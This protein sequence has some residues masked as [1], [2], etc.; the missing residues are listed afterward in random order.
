MKLISPI[1]SPHPVALLAGLLLIPA[2]S[3]AAQMAYEG[4]D[5]A[6]GTGNLTTQNGGSGWNGAWQTVNGTSADVAAGSLAAGAGSPSGYD[7]RSLGNSCNLLNGKRTGRFLNTSTN[8]PFGS[9]GYRDGNGNIG[10]DGT[11]LYLSFTQQPNDTGK[12]YE[13]EFHR[14]DLGDPGRIAGIG[15]DTD[16]GN[17]NLRAPNGT[18]TAIGTGSTAVN[19]YVVRIDFKAGNDD[20]YIY[21]NPTSATNPGSGAATL[22]RLA[23]ADMSFNGISFGAFVGTPARTVAHDEIRLGQTWDDV[24]TPSTSAPVFVTQPQAATTVL[25]GGSVGL[26]AVANGFPE[27]TCQWYKGVNPIDGQTSATLTLTDVQPGDAGAYHLVA[28]NSQNVATSADATVIV[29]PAPAGL[30]AYEGFDYDAGTSNTNGKTGGLGWGGA[31]TA[32]DGGGGNVQSGSLA[33]GTN[34]PNGYDARSSANSSLVPNAKR[35]GRLLDT[36]PGGRF[37][38]AGY[39]DSNGNVGMDGKTLYLSFLQQPDGTSLFYEFEFHRGNLGDPGRIAGIGNDT[40]NA[41]VN[42]RAPNN[43]QSLIGPGSTGVNLYVVRIDFKAGNDDVRI[44]QNPVSATEPGVPT[45]TKLDVADMSFNGLSLAAFVN[46]RT[47]KHDEIR[48]GQAW[49]D[50]IFGTS[51]RELTWVGDGVSNIWNY[52]APNWSAGTGTTAFVDGDPVTFGDTGFD[53]P[54]VNIPGNV[55]TALLTAAN[56]TKNHTLGGTGTITSSGGLMKSGS[57]SLTLNGP[58]IF[59]SAVVVDGGDLALNG[60]TTVGGGLNLNTGSGIVT[61][62]GTN[63][64]SGSLSATAG[65]QTLSGTNAFSGLVALNSSLT[66]SGPTRVTGGGGTTVWIGNLA[67]SNSSLTIESGGSLNMTGVFNDAWVIGRD[68]GSGSVIQNGGTVTYDPSNRNEAFI[69]A[70]ASGGTTASYLMN[71]GTLE[72]SN[73]RLG[74]SI[75]PISSTLTQTGG[76][77][78]VRQLDLGANLTTGTGNYSMTGGVLTLGAGGITTASGLYSI[79]LGGG[80]IASAADWSSS[81]TMTLNG[82]MS[83]DTGSHTVSLGG[84]LTGTGGLVKTGSGTLVLTALNGFTGPT[85]ITAGTLA[86]LG[87]SEESVLTVSSGAAI[88]PGVPG[89]LANNIGTFYCGSTLTMQSGSHLE[90]DIDSSISFSDQLTAFGHIDINGVHVSFN[91][92]AGGFI[93]PGDSLVIVESLSSDLF[94]KFAG[95]PEGSVITAGANT[96][97]IHYQANRVILTS[98]AGSAYSSWAKNNG[99]DATPGK[100]PAFDADPENDGISNGLEWILGGDPLGQDAASLVTTTASAASGLTLTFTREEASLGNATLIVEWDADLVG[101]WTSIPVTQAGGSY[102]G[103]VSVTVNQSAAPDAVTVHIPAAN[104]AGGKV[105]ARLRATMP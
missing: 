43:A 15:N 29:Q 60:T 55:S 89:P 90:L 56:S 63:T 75:G 91:E 95:Y 70:S 96:F 42:L 84:L 103:G 93:P 52:A 47:V 49:S 69:G 92:T 72:M 20:V 83:F 68:G 97:A 17:V 22:T 104:A 27:P 13:F 99:L 94:G 14:G 51:R 79:E 87:N 73:K 16:T 5:Y 7:L 40:A 67:G 48:L 28:T 39:V 10:K 80:T 35:D 62:G 41:I 34:A 101:T 98:I 65:T 11:T 30:L 105:F 8:G 54:A 44:Y 37:G 46:G 88:S 38:T 31:W 12:Y 102:V 81:M 6:T 9:R 57:G 33:A 2:A 24:I 58:A 36:T 85:T 53:S 32:V 77:I 1:F 3:Q 86:G 21:R 61:L 100:D 74:L 4:F 78:N 45:L 71:G 23:V 25:T 59:G 18:H 26:T 76:N 82:N 19:F 50:V 66:L 64:F